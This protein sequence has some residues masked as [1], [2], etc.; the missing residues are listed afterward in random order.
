[1]KKIKDPLILWAL[2]GVIGA[3]SR[4][5]YSFFA[6][7]IGFAKFYIWQ[8]GASLFLEKPLTMT[9]L[10]N[11][12]GF[13]TDILVGSFLGFI[14]GLFLKWRGKSY[15]ILKGW[16]VGAFA[17]L[18]FFGIL[19]TNVPN[20][21]DSAPNDILSNFSAF[22][23]HSIFGIATAI[24]YVKWLSKYEVKAKVK[25]DKRKSIVYVI[26]TERNGISVIKRIKGIF[27][28]RKRKHISD[29]N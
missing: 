2:S 21:K 6:K 24:A 20:L 25:S 18:A 19:V 28:K 10:G 12:L 7:Q 3:A 17:W 15:Y 16:G 4:D 29:I 5:V 8:I 11:M 1:M 9:F 23:G 26:N 14:F 22:V 13:L 27:F